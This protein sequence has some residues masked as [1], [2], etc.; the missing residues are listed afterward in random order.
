MKRC[1]V[2]FA[3]AAG[4]SVACADGEV[5]RSAL[6]FVGGLCPGGRAPRRLVGVP[7]PPDGDP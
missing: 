2:L 3:A 1:L 4:L 6:R 5:S 7:T